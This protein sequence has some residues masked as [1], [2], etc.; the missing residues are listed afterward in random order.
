VKAMKDMLL[1]TPWR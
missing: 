1:D